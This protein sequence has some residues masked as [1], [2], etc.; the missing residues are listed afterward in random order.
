MIN[1]EN[2][3]FQPCKEWIAGQIDSGKTW[4]DVRANRC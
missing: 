2:G 3:T 4:D 1:F